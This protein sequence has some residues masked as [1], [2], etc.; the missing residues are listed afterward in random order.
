MVYYRITVHFLGGVEYSWPAGHDD[1]PEG[2]EGGDFPEG[3]WCAPLMS[4]RVHERP[5]RDPHGFL[6]RFAETEDGKFLLG[7][8]GQPH[9]VSC[10]AEFTVP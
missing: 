4:A 5:Y 7:R 2:Y 8:H 10:E 3:E 6:A 1:E 9:A